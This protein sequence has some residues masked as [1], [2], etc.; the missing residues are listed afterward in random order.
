MKKVRVADDRRA[1]FTGKGN[2]SDNMTPEEQLKPTPEPAPE[3]GDR[4]PLDSSR[5]S[6]ARLGLG[7][8]VLMTVASQPVFGV[9]CGSNAMSGNLSDQNRGSCTKGWSPATILS[10]RNYGP[11]YMENHKVGETILAQCT[12]IFP[13]NDM[14]KTLKNR[15]QSGTELQKLS[16][17]AMINASASMTY[18]L[19]NEQLMQLLMTGTPASNGT[20]ASVT[21]RYNMPYYGMTTEEF[22]AWTMI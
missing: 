16:I 7:A 22:L 17:A 5:R 10:T 14:G 13:S 19:T 18:V 6:F 4:H 8:P 2:M 3:P 9:N 15:L 1:W 21:T 11:R 12:H 20:L